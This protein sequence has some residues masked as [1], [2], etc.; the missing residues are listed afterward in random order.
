MNDS[1]ERTRIALDSKQANYDEK[2]TK[3][4]ILMDDSVLLQDFDDTHKQLDP[5]LGLDY[6]GKPSKLNDY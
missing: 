6:D 3:L 5:Y 2:K 1:F 4:P